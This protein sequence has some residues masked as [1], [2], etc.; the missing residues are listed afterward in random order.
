VGDDGGGMTISGS[1]QTAAL[2]GLAVAGWSVVFAASGFLMGQP[3]IAFLVAPLALLGLV[4]VAVLAR[5]M[6]LGFDGSDV[7]Y[8]ATSSDKRIPKTDIAQCALVGQLWVF[9]DSA[10]AQLLALPASR[11]NQAGMTTFCN[12]AGI[13]LQAPVV[14]PIDQLRAAVRSGRLNRALGVGLLVLLLAAMAGS[15]YAQY[16]SR[17]DLR[18][19]EAAPACTSAAP[20][21]TSS[22]RLELQA[23]VRSVDARTSGATLHL[24]L[25]GLAGDYIAFLAYPTPKQ[26][27]TVAAE[28]WNGE[29]RQVEGR[30]TGANP[31]LN[32]NLNLAG[33]IAVIGLFALM[34]LLYAAVSQYQLM[35]A[36]EGLNHALNAAGRGAGRVQRMHSDGR[37]GDTGLPPCGIQHQP[38]EQ[39]FA[40]E[41]PATV[42][43]GLLI[44][45]AVAAVILGG[46]ILLAI[47]VSAPIFGGVTAIGLAWYVLQLFGQRR[48]MSLGGVYADD[49]HVAKIDTGFVAEFRRAVYGRSDVREVRMDSLSMTLVGV[50]GSNLFMSGAVSRAD[51]DRFATFLGVPVTRDSPAA[52]PD[53]LATPPVRTAAGV[54]PLR[55][56]RAAGLFQAI[57]GLMLVLALLNIPLRLPTQPVAQRGLL[58]GVL[59]AL[60]VYGAALLAVGL[61]LARGVNH[62]RQIALVGA[63]A[64][65][66]A[67][68]LAIFVA[69]AN[70]VGAAFFALIAIAIYA[71]AFYWLRKPPP[72]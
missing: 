1:R 7:V 69:T 13:T 66:V 4:A 17:E 38:K 23:V 43:R 26:G 33:G 11:F 59:G 28:L 15:A 35:K 10:G 9:S 5:P 29:V 58:L 44:V 22:C 62:A 39:F 55:I 42:R 31:T 53:A 12:M 51:R 36:T 25:A 71:L 3:R 48:E 21:N 65:T 20:A 64:A 67:M 34:A 14:R 61:V 6:T 70:A 63:G 41:D 37:V 47:F 18:R 8:R 60:A 57:G 46:L 2:I 16:S 24:S 49:L 27:E 30:P 19:Y 40:H 32:P 68:P 50:D 72:A 54:L 56:R 52:Q 45:S